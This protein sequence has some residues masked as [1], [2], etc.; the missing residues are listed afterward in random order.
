MGGV[1][2][3]IN[4]RADFQRMLDEAREITRRML[5]VSMD[6]TIKVIDTQLDAMQRWTANDREPTA[7]ERKTISVG[8]IAARSLDAEWTDDAGML[9]RKLFPLANFWDEWPTDDQAAN[10]TDADYWAR[11]G[12]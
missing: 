4:S 7:D 12:L 2:G 6:P 1:Y 8:V 5:K 3:A 10:A 9:A 11:F